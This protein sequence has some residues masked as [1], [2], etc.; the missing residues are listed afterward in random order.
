MT[1]VVR[2]ADAGPDRFVEEGSVV[3][4]EGAAPGSICSDMAQ[5]DWDCGD[6]SPIV[7]GK[8]I[9]HI[10]GDNGAYTVTLDVFA[11]NGSRSTD[12]AR[13]AVLNVAPTGDAGPDQVV[14]EGDTVHFSG[15]YTDPGFNDTHD[16][17]WAFGD[18]S[19]ETGKL[20]PTH[21]YAEDGVY[22]VT[23][24]VTDDDGG[25]GTD[26]LT[27]TVMN[28]APLVQL[29]GDKEIVDVCE[30]I[31]LNGTF[32]D[33]GLLD[34]HSY[35]WDFGDGGAIISDTLALTH[36]YSDSGVYSILLT[37]R[38][39]DGGEGE[40]SF[41]VTVNTEEA[42]LRNMVEQIDNIHAVGSAKRM[43]YLSQRF[44]NI[45]IE[46]LTRDQ[47]K[48][49]IINRIELAIRFLNKAQQRGAD[50]QEVINR[51]TSFVACQ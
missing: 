4:F 42:S 41:S 48:R 50:T 15:A 31:N 51:L 30:G 37:V 36:S 43:L 24:T 9:D 44:L 47:N 46:T 2:N 39:D 45:A 25:V 19:T 8:N 32:T 17:V 11:D 26:T 34:S 21:S 1:P 28:V 14:D 38:D 27:G 10:Y 16:I 5:Y 49:R 40:A 20:N 7:E 23:L 35:S 3:S 12:T 6:G 18:G 29:S 22:A 33:P 13:V